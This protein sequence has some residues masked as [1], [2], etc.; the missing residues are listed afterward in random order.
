MT[1]SPKT[2][3]DIDRTD[4]HNLRPWQDVVAIGEDEWTVLNSGA[5]VYVTDIDGNKMIDGPGG[6]WCVNVGHGRKEIIDAVVKQMT[7]LSYVSP[8]SMAAPITTQLA[9]RLA[10]LA[11]GDYSGNRR[12]QHRCLHRRTHYGIRRRDRPARRVFQAMPCTMQKA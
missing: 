7:S 6:M 12:R 3:Q 10:G 2:H 9:E 8:W 5:G 1:A 11:P 4:R